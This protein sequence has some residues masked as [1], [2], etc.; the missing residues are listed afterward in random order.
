MSL[1]QLGPFE[2]LGHSV[3]A[4]AKHARS[5]GNVQWIVE[6]DGGIQFAAGLEARYDDI[7]S[8][9]RPHVEEAVRRYL[10]R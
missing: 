1:E 5:A 6:L 3:R 9:V 10:S 4:F 2:F 8:F 7:E